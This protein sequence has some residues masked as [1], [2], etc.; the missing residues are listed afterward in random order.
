[1]A[2]NMEG[3]VERSEMRSGQD[4]GG[5]LAPVLTQTHS[6]ILGKWLKNTV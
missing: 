4:S 5:A 6:V 1:M 2:R 3:A